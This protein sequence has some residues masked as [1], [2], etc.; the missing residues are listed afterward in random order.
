MKKRIPILPVLVLISAPVFA[1]GPFF[2]EGALGVGVDGEKTLVRAQAG[3]SYEVTEHVEIGGSVFYQRVRRP[4]AQGDVSTSLLWAR[5]LLP[6]TADTTAFVEMGTQL[7]PIT[8]TWGAGL[9]YHLTAQ[10]QVTVG[11]RYQRDRQD[12]HDETLF[13]VGLRTAI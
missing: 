7:A 5:G 8:P 6:L 12:D 1:Q 11:Y 3:L 4:S 9:R 13:M 2:W 10:Q